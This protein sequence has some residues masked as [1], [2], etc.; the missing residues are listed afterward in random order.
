M[1]TSEKISTAFNR[2]VQTLK[3]K[4]SFGMATAVSRTVVTDGLTCTVRERDW[5]FTVDMSEEVGGNAAGP[6]PGV[7]GRAALG[8]C[9]AIGYM[10]RASTMGICIQSLSVEIQADFDDG[11]LFG[12]SPD[13]V[14]PGYSEVRYIISV[15]T[16]AEESLVME[17]LDEADRH[18]PYLN[19]FSR[20]QTCL[21][22]VHISSPKKLNHG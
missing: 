1:L 2:I 19:V 10:M 6:T 12:T 18:S 7:Y 5:S 16:E 14:S 17:L 21:R 4:P 3:R 9:L 15:E 22:Q 8:S 11:A 13:T 20:P